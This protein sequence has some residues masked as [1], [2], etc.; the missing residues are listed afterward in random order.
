MTR[1]Q[2]GAHEQAGRHA[3]QVA[4][5][6][7]EEYGADEWTDAV[8]ASMKLGGID[9]LFFV[10][11]TEIAYYQEAVV[12][13]EVR[14]RRRRSSSPCSTNRRRCTRRSARRW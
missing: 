8:V 1:F 6:F 13:A 11:G 2:G 4:G 7:W 12:K 3:F 14:T 5:N 10:S 9:H